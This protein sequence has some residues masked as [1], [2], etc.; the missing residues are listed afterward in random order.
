MVAE[1]EMVLYL[2]NTNEWF[3]SIG[4]QRNLKGWKSYVQVAQNRFEHISMMN[5]EFD[6]QKDWP[7]V[8]EPIL[9]SLYTNFHKFII[10]TYGMV[11]N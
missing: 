5:D 6:K 10:F 9:F 8:L 3:K 2:L 7:K 4:K 1:S 11:M